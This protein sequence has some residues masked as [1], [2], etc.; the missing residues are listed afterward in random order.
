MYK[1]VGDNLY[2]KVSNSITSNRINSLADSQAVT[3]N[4]SSAL[5]SGVYKL[6]FV[7]KNGNDTQKATEDL[8]FNVN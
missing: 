7:L 4:H 6:E 2:N 5:G 8:V 3:L 1:Q